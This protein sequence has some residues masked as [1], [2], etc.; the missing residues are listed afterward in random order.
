MAVE[1]LVVERDDG[2]VTLTI[3][4]PARK[5]AIT[6]DMWQ[7]LVDLFDE[8]GLSRADRVLVITGAG[9]AFCSGA[10]LSGV[11]ESGAFGGVGGAVASMRVVGRAALRLHEL[12]IPTIAAVNGVAAGAGCNLALGCDLI[13]ASERA[14]FTEIFAK[15]GL[16]LDFGGSWI[17]P[18]LVGLHRAKELA[19]LAEIVDAR[20]AERIGLV[21]RV[22]EADRLAD[23]V[24]TLA[25][26]LADG[27]PL[28][29]AVIK[30]QLNDAMAR[31]MAEAVEAEA[32]AQA[33]VSGSSDSR[34]AMIAFLQKRD[35]HFTGE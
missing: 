4:R 15:R 14:R 18:R 13:I 28:Q 5:N 32:Y 21:N 30:R 34:E 1:G 9:E 6:L 22:V 25:R 7:G 26:R 10:D 29:L 20:E 35:P 33:L 24:R 23:E 27:A 11:A 19:F 17:L 16:V 8:I 3:D 2:V 31:T 12:P